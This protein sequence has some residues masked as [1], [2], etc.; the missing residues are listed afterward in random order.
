MKP[1][2]HKKS[3]KFS[4][5]SDSDKQKVID[6]QTQIDPCLRKKCKWCKD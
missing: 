1:E 6:S 3:G 5:L 2:T 4:G